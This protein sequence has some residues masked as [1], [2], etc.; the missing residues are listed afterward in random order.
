MKHYRYKVSDT[1]SLD[2]FWNGDTAGFLGDRKHSHKALIT[3]DFKRVKI[4]FQNN[5]HKVKLKTT[6]WADYVTRM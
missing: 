1:I 4:Q 6:R 2:M 5:I 3:F